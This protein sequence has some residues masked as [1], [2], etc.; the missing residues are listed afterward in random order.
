[1]GSAA[2]PRALV[3]AAL[4]LGGALLARGGGGCAGGTAAAANLV[5]GGS[6]DMHQ[7]ACVAEDGGLGVGDSEAELTGP[8]PCQLD[9]AARFSCGIP[10]DEGPSEFEGTLE[11]S[12][13][14]L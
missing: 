5:G 2:F 9:G 1:M 6:N 14:Q 10:H 12:A 7:Y 13:G 4:F 8:S 11:L 3:R